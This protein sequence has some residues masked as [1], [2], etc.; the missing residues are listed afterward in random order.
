MKP[1]PV[2]IKH[3]TFDISSVRILSVRWTY[4][5]FAEFGWFARIETAPYTLLVTFRFFFL[6]SFLYFF[7]PLCLS[8]FLPFILSSVMFSA[9]PLFFFLCFLS[10]FLPLCLRPCICLLWKCFANSLRKTSKWVSLN[11][12]LRFL[13]SAAMMRSQW[14]NIN[15]TK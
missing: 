7:P 8:S 6:T 5:Y 13:S 15:W 4:L 1:E 3:L 9:V 14:S 12:A 10:F 2:Y 11:W